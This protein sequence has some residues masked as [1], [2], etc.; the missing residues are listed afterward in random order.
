MYTVEG[1]ELRIHLLDYMHMTKFIELRK[2]LVLYHI[3]VYKTSLSPTLSLSLSLSKHNIRNQNA[4]QD[5][6]KTQL[7]YSGSKHSI[8]ELLDHLNMWRA[9]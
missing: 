6:I 9:S 8:W 3:H 1:S 7:S 4:M 5:P 2:A